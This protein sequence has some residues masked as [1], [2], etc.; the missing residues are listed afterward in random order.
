[1]LSEKVPG[2][3]DD[4]KFEA[5]ECGCCKDK[6]RAMTFLRT[7]N[8]PSFEAIVFLGFK[9]SRLGC[10]AWGSDFTIIQAHRVNNLGC[11]D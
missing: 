1:M 4:S 6:L 2:Q 9:V 10:G 8:I 3:N 5:E 7:S 11:R